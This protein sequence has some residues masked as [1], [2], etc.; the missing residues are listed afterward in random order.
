MKN[1]LSIGMLVSASALVGAG[2]WA[3]PA[4]R[5]HAKISA[6]QASKTA[7]AKYHGKVVGKVALENEDGKWEY[8]VNVKSGAILREVMVDANT[9]K[10]ASV[11][12]TSAA[13]EAAEARAEKA[14]AAKAPPHARISAAQ[15]TK[16]ALAKYPGTVVGKVALEN[17]GGKWQYAVNVKSGGVL[18][19]VMVDANTNKVASVE[20]TTPAEEAG[21]AKAEKAG[22]E[23]AEPSESGETGKKGES[24]ETE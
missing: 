13:E 20:V 23:K 1:R 19:E 24:G 2:A 3:A 12:V 6:A 18:R 16:T 4:A 22:V 21:E 9:N 15:A 10:I 17:E 5:P 11:E 7:L 8:A 14:A